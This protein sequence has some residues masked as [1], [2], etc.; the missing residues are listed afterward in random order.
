MNV[1]QKIET[2]YAIKQFCMSQILERDS[3]LIPALPKSPHVQPG[4][5]LLQYVLGNKVSYS[6]TKRSSLL[7][8]HGFAWQ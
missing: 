1:W 6:F 7:F 4:Q 3:S 2:K 8:L 5:E